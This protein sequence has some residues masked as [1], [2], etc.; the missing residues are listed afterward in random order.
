MTTKILVL[1]SN[2]HNTEQLG[3]N[4]EFSEIEN[5]RESSRNKDQFT[6]LRVAQARVD[7]L[8]REIIETKARIVHF[9]GHGLGNQGLVLETRDGQ[10][11]LVSTEAL[12]DLFKLLAQQ[13]ECVILNA[14]YSE[15]QAAAI[16][17]HIN[18]VIGTNNAI[19]DNVAIAFSKGF[20][21]GLFS[22]YFLFKLKRK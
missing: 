8:Q 4:R 3:L 21:T 22:Q 13:V 14:C 16:H 9:C 11:Q 6:V 12:A 20:Y 10:Q 19:K 18:Y 7:H 17:Q 2:P 1:S 5:A 15:A